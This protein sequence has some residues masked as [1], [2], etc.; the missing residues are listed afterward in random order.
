MEIK[1]AND[2]QGEGNFAKKGDSLVAHYT[3]M[4]TTGKVFDSSLGQ[5]TPFSFVV[6][7]G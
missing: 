7:A 6:G 5:G 4:L 3:G 1:V 2:A